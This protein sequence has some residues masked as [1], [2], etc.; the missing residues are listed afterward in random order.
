MLIASSD[1]KGI[2][3]RE[4]VP[5]DITV[6]SNFYCDAPRRMSGNVRRKRPEF[7]RYHNWLLYHDNAPAY[8]SLKN[9]E[10]VTNNNKVTFPHPPYSPDLTAL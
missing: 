1:V 4:F 6:N 3:H 8:T 5:P 10:V 9:T 7:W 2:V